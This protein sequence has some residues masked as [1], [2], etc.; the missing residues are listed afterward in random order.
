MTDAVAHYRAQL[1]G[2]AGLA[3]A[4]PRRGEDDL[5]TELYQRWFAP[6]TGEPVPALHPQGRLAHYRA[7]DAASGRFEA[8]WTV[9]EVDADAASPW[10]IP[11]ARGNELRWV[12][13]GDFLYPGATGLR[14][15][16]GAAIEVTARRDVEF[17]GWWSTLSAAWEPS[18]T[19][20]RLYWSVRPAHVGGLIETLT[21]NLDFGAPWA[22]KAPLLAERLRHPD[23]VVLY[24]ATSAWEH[25]QPA[26]AKSL[27][28]SAPGLRDELPALTL[29]VAPGV[30]LAEDPGD[31]S[32]GTQRC[33]VI[34]EGLSHALGRGADTPGELCRAAEAA[35]A[36]HGISIAAPYLHRGSRSE[37]RLAAA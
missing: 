17:D 4:T 13:P 20:L 11:A 35:L 25:L 1:L 21:T 31:E 18:G 23:A 29:M 7:A 30:G 33:R 27:R 16:A 12:D 24:V 36:R 2:A 8:G 37:Y 10:Q 19:V 26:I 28:R 22:L 9:A 14:P 6:P 15:P 34:A 32:F 3:L 5:A